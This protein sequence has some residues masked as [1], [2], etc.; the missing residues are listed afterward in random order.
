[1]ALGDKTTFEL[2]RLLLEYDDENAINI[3]FSEKVQFDKFKQYILEEHLIQ[4]DIDGTDQFIDT[5]V[6]VLDYDTKRAI[7]V[8]N[9]LEE[10]TDYFLGDYYYEDI[11]FPMSSKF[12]IEL[13][14]L[15]D[16]ITA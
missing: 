8:L 3:I 1:M 4:I 16:F 13:S 15:M 5:D 2:E 11:I 12:K 14:D 10:D 6:V 9:K 7:F